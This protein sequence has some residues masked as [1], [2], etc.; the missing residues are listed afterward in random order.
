MPLPVWTGMTGGTVADGGGVLGV[1]EELVAG[2][3]PGKNRL[4][5][6]VG[7]DGVT[8]PPPQG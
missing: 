7:E 5:I 6:G 4:V 3:V 2:A 1:V 8:Q